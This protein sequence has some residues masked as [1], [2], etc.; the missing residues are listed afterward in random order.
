MSPD[1]DAP[2]NFTRAVTEVITELEPGD[3]MTYGEV[4]AEAG[5][6]GAARAVG[7]ILRKSDGLPWWRIVSS[8][9][10][11]V[12]GNEVEHERLLVAEGLTV[13]DGKVRGR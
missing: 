8:T 12:P 11:L 5:F 6:P 1:T 2:S 3:V 9:G 10:R 7:Q 4:A 13:R